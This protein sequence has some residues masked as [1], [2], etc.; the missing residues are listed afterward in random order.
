MQ[1]ANF[2][3]LADILKQKSG[4]NLSEDKSYLLES[5]LMPIA[6]AHKM[7]DLDQL[8]DAVRANSSPSLVT[9]IIEAMTTNES[10]FFRDMKPFDQ[11]R[12]VVIPEIMKQQGANKKIRIWSAACSTGQEPYTI[13]MFL[14]EDAA[15]FLGWKFEIHASDLAKK[16]VDRAQ[17]G[18]FTQFEAQRGLPIQLLIKYFNQLPDT[19]WE[20]KDEIRKSITYFTFNLLDQYTRLGKFEIVFCRNVLIYFDDEDKKRV[21]EKM[22]S[23]LSPHGVLILGSTETLQDSK[24][25][26]TGVP[27]LR[28]AYRLK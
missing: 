9:E 5:R 21:A 22:A 28:G 16:V 14:K 10:S 19:N 20:I 12:N 4:L 3:T 17:K 6:R 18:V 11:L 27:E 23:V 15:K 1:S 8:A 7:S 13:S 2:K 25:L 26:F 24:G